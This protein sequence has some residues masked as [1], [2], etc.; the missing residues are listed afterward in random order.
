MF[1]DE[2]IAGIEKPHGI[3]LV[4]FVVCEVLGLLLRLSF[5]SITRSR[6]ASIISGALSVFDID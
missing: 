5:F 1:L 3:C 4:T 2:D 6:S